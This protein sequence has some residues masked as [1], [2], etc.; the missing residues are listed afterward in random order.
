MLQWPRYNEKSAANV[1]CHD[2]AT[3]LHPQP[4]LSLLT[5]S[6]HGC[7]HRAT[8]CHGNWKSTEV[9]LATI[10]DKQLHSLLAVQRFSAYMAVRS[11]SV[12]LIDLHSSEILH[13]FTTETM[14]PRSLKFVY[15]GQRL[16][17]G[18]RGTVSSLTL[19]YNSAET[20]DLVLQTYLPDEKYDNI[21]FSNATGL[22]GH[23]SCCWI[24]TR[25]IVRRVCNPGT[26][27]PLRN[28]SFLGV[29]RTEAASQGSPTSN[30]LPVFA[31]SGLRRRGGHADAPQP[32]KPTWEAWVITRLE[33]EGH[34]ET[35]QCDTSQD[36][37]GLF[38][39]ELGPM[40]KV[41]QGSVAVGFGNIIKVLT[42]GHEWYDNMDEESLQPDAALLA[43]R[44][45]RR[46]VSRTRATSATFRAP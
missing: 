21:C 25:Q 43:S 14:Q 41:G 29:R 10:E 32:S 13:T 4:R 26:W 31:Q 39:N 30:R 15:S 22:F 34:V 37:A 40:V 36:S 20:G 35:L 5:L 12:D 7:I 23:S 24:E 3:A 11:R 38:I 18:G 9:K 44:R 45:R 33:N 2:Q 6:R 19:A 27:A 42:V 16:S 17:P 1:F 46:P 8:L 28:G